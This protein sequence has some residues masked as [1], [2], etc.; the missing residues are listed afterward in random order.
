LSTTSA[1]KPPFI[2]PERDPADP[3]QPQDKIAEFKTSLQDYGRSIIKSALEHSVEEV[4]I[5][6]T[7]LITSKEKVI[8]HHTDV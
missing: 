8:A 3:H 5:L 1:H 2:K 7:N 4:H 6:E